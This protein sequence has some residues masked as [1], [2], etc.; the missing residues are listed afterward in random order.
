MTNTAKTTIATIATAMIAAGIAA[1]AAAQEIHEPALEA[2]IQGMTLETQSRFETRLMAAHATEINDR[3][4]ALNVV[5]FSITDASA[6]IELD[7]EEAAP[8]RLASAWD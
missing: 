4:A 3:L 1:P 2:A 6:E 8:T 5:A 7:A